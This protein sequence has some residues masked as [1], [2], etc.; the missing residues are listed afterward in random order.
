MS[1]VTSPEM[2]ES[3]E[4]AHLRSGLANKERLLVL[5]VKAV[6]KT[7]FLDT[8]N[9]YGKEWYPVGDDFTGALRSDFPSPVTRYV[10]QAYFDVEHVAD[11]NYRKTFLKKINERGKPWIQGIQ[12]DLL[13]WHTD[14]SMLP[15]LEHVKESTGLELFLQAHGDAMSELG[16]IGVMRRLGNTALLLDYLLFDASHGT[17]KR[18]DVASLEPFIA[19]AYEQTDENQTGIA[20]AGGLN[21]EVVAEDLPEIVDRY[22]HL[23]WDAEGQLH[24]VDSNGKRP[25]DLDAV[26]GYLK[27]SSSILPSVKRDERSI[28]NVVIDAEMYWFGGLKQRPRFPYD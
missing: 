12:F 10:A 13:P 11:E 16:P 3:I 18:L 27:A 21:A 8:E 15:F 4:R 26:E 7:Q 28:Q 17:G 2:Q 9:K 5:G 6:H 14:D 20:I 1:G 22:P 24:P 19:E 23:S 25:L